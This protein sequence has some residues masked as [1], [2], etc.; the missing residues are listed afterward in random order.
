VGTGKY[1]EISPLIWVLSVL[2]LLR[3]MFLGSE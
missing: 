2:F 1:R 3:Y